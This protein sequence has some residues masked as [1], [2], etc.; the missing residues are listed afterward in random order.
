MLIAGI[1]NCLNNFKSQGD[2]T[3]QQVA[4]ICSE[5]EAAM[6]KVSQNFRNMALDFNDQRQV[7]N[8]L[9]ENLKACQEEQK[10]FHTRMES[11]VDDLRRLSNSLSNRLGKEMAAGVQLRQDVSLL[12]AWSKEMEDGSMVVTSDRLQKLEDQMA[13]KD[14]EI[15]ALRE[16]VC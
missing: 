6:L 8:M 12:M 11:S 10:V 15:A 9:G 14:A 16:K 4:G 3:A 13:E 5:L 7:I 1:I 2:A